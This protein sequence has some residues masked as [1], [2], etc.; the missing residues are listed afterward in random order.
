MVKQLAGP[1]GLAANLPGDMPT[2]TFSRALAWPYFILAA[3]VLLAFTFF[4]YGAIKLA[5]YQFG[6]SAQ[7]LAQPLGQV[8]LDHLAWYCFDQQPFKTFVGVS[9]IVAAL[10][11]LHPRTVLLGALLLLP[12]AVN[13]FVIDLT[14]LRQIVAFRY[15]LPFHLG[16]LALIFWHYRAAVLVAWQALTQHL[17]ARLAYPWW[18]YMLLPL[19]A[20]A[21]NLLWLLPK[22]AV[23]F[24][25]YPAATAHY[26]G[27]LWQLVQ[28]WLR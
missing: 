5:G 3:R 7:V 19:A 8:S 10:L 15:M 16:L 4:G 17:G 25:Y 13:I 22:Y 18:S 24:Y 11:L 2:P 14:Y 21:L 26:F 27:A 28:G 23:D 12:I 9:Q 1:G 20:L 6:V